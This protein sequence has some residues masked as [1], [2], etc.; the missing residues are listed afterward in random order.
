MLLL[1]S[2]NYEKGRDLEYKN[3][4]AKNLATYKK[5][6]PPGCVLKGVY[7]STFN[8]GQYDVTW[9]WEFKK[10][11]DLDAVREYSDPVMEKLWIEEADFYVPGSMNTVILRDVGE[12][13]VLPPKKSKRSR[14]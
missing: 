6:P 7:G 11:A 10:F 4:M 9:I 14:K 5:R 8:I 2:A 3:F 1:W 12:W 13:S